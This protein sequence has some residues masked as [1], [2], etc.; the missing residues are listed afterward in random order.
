M[1]RKNLLTFLILFPLLFCSQ[2]LTVDSSYIVCK[3][4][5]ISYVDTLDSYSKY[6][7]LAS[8]QIGDNVSHFKSIQKY[9][10]DSLSYAIV[11]K[12]FQNATNGVVKLNTGSIPK[13][14][15]I[16]EVYVNKDKVLIY[17]KLLQ[18]YYSYV[19][20][21]ICTWTLTK[22][23]KVISGYKCYKAIG[24]YGKRSIDAWYT[25]EVPIPEGPYNFKGLPGLIIE[26]EDKQK[27]NH[28]IL[29]SLQRVKTPIKL[30][31]NS[32]ETSYERYN[33]K[34]KQVLA[35]PVSFIRARFNIP[36]EDEE[37]VNRNVRKRNNFLD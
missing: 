13:A 20:Q 34:R 15:F 16:S 9:I 24:K 2:K 33:E 5:I 18:D 29:Q 28:F 11:E 32:V 19:P 17:D 21:S 31:V 7:E 8:L 27:H 36:K 23:M 3:Y 30:I 10:S 1:K 4:K 12:G 25:D 26:L 6:E 37:R 22:E 14:L 35:D